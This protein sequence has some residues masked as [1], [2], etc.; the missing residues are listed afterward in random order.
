MSHLNSLTSTQKT[1]LRN[2][3]ALI[4]GETKDSV[5]TKDDLR[6][7]YSTLG[8]PPPTEDQ[9]NSMLGDEDKGINFTQ[10]SNIMAKE[11]SKFEDRAVIYE[12]LK[13]FTNDEKSTGLTIDLQE[14]KEACCSVQLGEIGSGDHRLSRSTFD[15]LVQGFV[16]EQVNGKQVF[17]ATKWL[18]AYI[19]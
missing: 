18:D 16:Q 17:L 6:K 13:T 15:R 4:D 9:L 5:I 3:F 1:Q 12:A 8:L 11:L 19:D 7:L 10:F 2:A 14:F